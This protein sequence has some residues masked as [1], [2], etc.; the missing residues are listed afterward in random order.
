MLSE[1]AHGA[2]RTRGPV[3]G[4]EITERT[5]GFHRGPPAQTVFARTVAAANGGQTMEACRSWTGGSTTNVSSSAVTVDM[6]AFL[7]DGA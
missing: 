3:S 2:G 7:A 4:I 5:R 1:T 6:A